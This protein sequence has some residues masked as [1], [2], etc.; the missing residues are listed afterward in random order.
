MTSIYTI[1]VTYNAM[2]RNW[3]KRCMDSLAK[4]TVQTIPVVIDN[5]STDGTREYFPQHYPNAVWLPQSKNLGF[6]QANNVGIRYALKHQADYVL[7]LNQDAAIAPDAIEKML[8]ASDKESLLSPIHLNGDGTRIDELFRCTL[9]NASN[10]M[11][12]DLLIRHTLADS[13]VTG[14]ICAACWLMPVN[15]IIKIG[16]FNP[17]FFHYSE[18][19]NYYHRMTFHGVKTIL[20]PHAQM[21]HDRQV[22]GNKQAYNYK[23]L[24][25]DMILVACNINNNF[26]RC[27]KEW[28]SILG[29][30]YFIDLPAKNYLPGRYLLELIW[31]LSHAWKI[32][33]SR[34]N[35]KKNGK[36]WL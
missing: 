4:S 19:N 15:I 8:K 18:D 3:I 10:T 12:D 2:Q 33:N 21:Y 29:R 36:T 7:L 30:C 13:Y 34:K 14:E 35:E 27:C 22:Y 9:R 28:L 11:N 5:G 1:I 32:R 26:F 17:L 31:M 6:G 23:L 16:G 25:R 20:V 24:H